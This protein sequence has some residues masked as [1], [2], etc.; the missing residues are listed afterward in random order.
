VLLTRT[1]TTIRVAVEG[2]ADAMEFSDIDGVWVA[3]NREP[4]LI[5]FAWQRRHPKP[6]VFE[7]DCCCSDELA[8]RLIHSLFTDSEDRI[9]GAAS[10]ESRPFTASAT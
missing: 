6:A 5:E 9:A 10:V 7:A 1:E 4:V 2:A 3:A 8:A